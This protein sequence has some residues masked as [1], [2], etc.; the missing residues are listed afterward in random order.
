MNTALLYLTYLPN[1]NWL[2]AFTSYDEIVVER[3]ENFIKSTPR[4]RCEIAGA[5]GRQTLSIPII[6]GRDHHQLYK[7]VR[8]SYQNDWQRSHWPSIRSAY[9]SAPYFEHY[10]DKFL[11]LYERQFD[12]L[13]EYNTEFLN[14]I[15]PLLRIDKKIKF[16]TSY[17]GQVADMVDLRKDGIPVRNDNDSIG[18]DIAINTK[19]YYQVFE[20]RNGFIPNLS[21]I[22]LLMNEGPGATRYLT[23]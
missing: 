22:D 20:Q 12:L 19:R 16:T 11:P 4:N 7:D 23:G 6:G 5:N 17:E 8:I 10:A 2:R 21:I 15:L 14:A 3:E 1:I 9:G 13:F 18:N